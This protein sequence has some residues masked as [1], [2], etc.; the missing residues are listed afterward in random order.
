MV[1]AIFS[2]IFVGESGHGSDGRIVRATQISQ[3]FIKIEAPA[4]VWIFSLDRCMFD[5][6]LRFD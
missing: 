2:D 5:P 6:I 4:S 1:S 3:K